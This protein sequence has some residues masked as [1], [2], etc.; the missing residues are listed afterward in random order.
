MAPEPGRYKPG[1]LNGARQS[2]RRYFRCGVC[3][4]ALRAM[5]AARVYLSEGGN[6][7]L[8]E[9]AA[10]HGTCVAYVQAGVTLIKAG[11]QFLIHRVMRGDIPIL[12]AAK[13]VEPLVQM[14]DGYSKATPENK[15]AFFTATGCTDDLGLHLAASSATERTEGAKRFG[16]AEALWEQMVL[17]LVQAAA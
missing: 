13:T 17:P 1:K 15:G 11:D 10:R 6:I 5:T 14:L 12:K 16:N 3:A 7:S 8:V 9:A 2:S 4:A